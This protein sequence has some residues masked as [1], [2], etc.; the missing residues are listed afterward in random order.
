MKKTILT[1]AIIAGLALTLV[2]AKAFADEGVDADLASDIQLDSQ[3]EQNDQDQLK[4]DFIGNIL[5]AVS[6]G[7]HDPGAF[8]LL[9]PILDLVILGPIRGYHQRGRENEQ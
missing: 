8:E 3:F 2:T 6:G 5:L 7:F 4:A 9:Q 1:F